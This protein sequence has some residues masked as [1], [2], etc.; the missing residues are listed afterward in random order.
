MTVPIYEFDRRIGEGAYGNVIQAYDSI[1]GRFVAIK[2]I[3]NAWSSTT[4]D[5]E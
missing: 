2:T 4:G 1:S 5:E 3:H